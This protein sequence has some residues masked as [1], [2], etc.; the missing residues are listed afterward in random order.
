MIVGG[1]FMR[2]EDKLTAL[3]KQAGYT[4]QEIAEL[5]GVERSSYAGYETGKAAIPIRKIQLLSVIYN[6]DLNAFSTSD[7]LPLRSPDPIRDEKEEEKNDNRL[8]KDERM[9]L[10]KIRIIRAQGRSKELTDLLE[11]M[12][13]P[14]E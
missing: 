5:I 10:A 9:L 8:T 2:L 4:Q 12:A 6:V 7:V 14:E 11:K 13:D 3:R 1:L